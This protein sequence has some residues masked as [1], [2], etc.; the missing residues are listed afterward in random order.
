M[1]GK[2]ASTGL[3]LDPLLVAAP[4]P[5]EPRSLLAELLAFEHPGVQLR[6]EVGDSILDQD[7]PGDIVHHYHP[8]KCAR[9]SVP[10]ETCS[11][12]TQFVPTTSPTSHISNGFAGRPL[13]GAQGLTAF[14]VKF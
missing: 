8:V 1:D 6:G 3:E 10:W 11:S 4:A 14:S 13:G 2:F 9:V 5:R 7:R 12:K